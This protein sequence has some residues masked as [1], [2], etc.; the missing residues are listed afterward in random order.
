MLLLIANTR[1]E[2]LRGININNLKPSKW[3][4]SVNFS[5]LR[6]LMH[7]SRVHCIEMAGYKPWQ[8]EYKIFS[9][10]CRF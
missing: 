7:I 8:P 3:G 6:A 2:L 1:D 4:I 9:I 5:Q 10:E